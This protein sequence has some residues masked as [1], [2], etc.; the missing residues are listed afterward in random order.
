[1]HH[2]EKYHA[3]VRHMQIGKITFKFLLKVQ[4]HL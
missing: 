1:M 3:D 2:T 4:I